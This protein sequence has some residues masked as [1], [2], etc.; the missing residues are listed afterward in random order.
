MRTYVKGELPRLAG[1]VGFEPTHDG[2]RDRSLT[3]WRYPTIF[4]PISI[5]LK[6]VIVNKIT[7]IKIK[8][9]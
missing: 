8:K 7:N 9:M 5:T 1:V 2:F 6:A 4:Y 3:A